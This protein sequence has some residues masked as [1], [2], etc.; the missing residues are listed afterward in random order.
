M[1]RFGIDLGTSNTCIYVANSGVGLSPEEF[2]LNRV[3]I[4]YENTGRVTNPPLLQSMPSAIYGRKKTEK[5]DEYEI[6][7]GTIAIREAAEDGVPEIINTK[8]LLCREEPD[9]LIAYN[10]TAKD[11]AQKLL[12]GCFYSIQR[13]FSKRQIDASQF[14]ITQPAAFGLFA[15][16]SIQD[17]ATPAG[18][19]DAKPLREPIAALLSLLYD[20]LKNQT[21]AN[22][23]F[24]KQKNS[25]GRLL[26]LICDIGG[27]T[28]DV[29]IQEIE[30]SGKED[31]EK[32]SLICTGYKIRFLN[33]AIDETKTE[34]G[35]VATANQEPAF[36]GFDF[37]KIIVQHIIKEW[38]EQ[39]KAN[40]G[41]NCNW[42]SPGASNE[43][44][45]LYER[46]R[47][48][49]N[50]LSNYSEDQ[51]VSQEEFASLDGI[52]LTCN[53][54]SSMVYD[55][56][57]ELCEPMNG[58]KETEK[59][60]Y[61]IIEDTIRRSGY[62]IEDI[63]YFFVTGGMSNYRPIRDMLKK[64][65]YNLFQSGALVFSDMPLDDI[66]RGAAVCDCFFEV[67]MPQSVLYADLMV[68][69][70]CGE[71]K[72][73]VKKNHELPASGIEYNLF[74]LRNPVYLYVDILQGL[75]TKDCTIKRLRRLRKRLPNRIITPIGTNV[76]VKWKIDAHQ[77]MDV[78]LIVHDPNE[79]Y[80]VQLLQLIKDIDLTE[81]DSDNG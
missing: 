54:N 45:W 78:E 30:V 12:E 26:T 63:D 60:V 34:S 6:Y 52:Q 8:R 80:T 27:G 79:E 72:I 7:L 56:T 16:R 38:D 42:N 5:E 24:E 73:L 2:M 15:S 67:D 57:Q 75:G 77:A 35:P 23:L 48:F 69:D 70:P 28:T 49:K 81:G 10:L 1:R 4:H 18:F 31:P 11:I 71:P 61:G 59:T 22:E 9:T 76:S 66:A 53:F 58:N 68:D 74:Q 41:Y 20:R 39:Y 19:S 65:F 47:D 64:R 37:D 33:Q 46:V 44:F 29:T 51:V 17:A 14:C 32:G 36:G 43:V 62:K 40:R 25:G 21:T 50:S 13:A 3:D 55:W